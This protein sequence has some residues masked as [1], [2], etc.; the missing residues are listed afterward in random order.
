MND[1]SCVRLRAEYKNYVWSYDFVEDKTA[2]RRKLRWLNIIDEVKHKCLFHN[3]QSI[4]KTIVD[5]NF[6]K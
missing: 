4:G 3:P 6:L 2:D 5:K 1:G